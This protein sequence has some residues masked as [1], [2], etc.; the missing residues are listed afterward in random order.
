MELGP[1]SRLACVLGWLLALAL[2]QDPLAESVWFVKPLR[3]GA[4][5]ASRPPPPPVVVVGTDGSGT[6]V[7]AK[8]LAL[9]N[10]SVLVE[11][12]VYGQMDVDGTSAGVHF[13]R[14]I[15]GVLNATHSPRYDL[16][17]LPRSLADATLDALWPFALSMV[18]NADGATRLHGTTRWG[19]K[20]PDLLNLG[21]FVDHLFPGVK[22]VHV[23]RDGRDMAFSRNAAALHKYAFQLFPPPSL[24]GRSA[25]VQKLQLW[26]KQNLE[27]ARWADQ[28]LGPARCHR[29][30]IEDIAGQPDAG[31]LALEKFRALARFVAAGGQAVDDRVVVQAVRQLQSKSLGSHDARAQTKSVRSQFGKWRTL[32]DP[33]LQGELT[34]LAGTALAQFGYLEEQPSATDRPSRLRDRHRRAA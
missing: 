24:S 1:V 18:Q 15:Q 30:K 34:R 31:G 20:K 19:F 16:A 4:P 10:V 9:T 14:T 27:F 2:A 25:E 17:A 8:F 26:Q 21:P 23:V 11:R 12:G 32:A 7:I 3:R 13:T 28:R 5:Q 6:R 22:V 29:V 33:A